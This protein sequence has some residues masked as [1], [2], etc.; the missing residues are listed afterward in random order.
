MTPVRVLSERLRSCNP[1][2][3]IIGTEA[4]NYGYLAELRPEQGLSAM[5]SGQPFGLDP[6][7]GCGP[8]ANWPRRCGARSRRQTSAV[9]DRQHRHLGLR[10]RRS[11]GPGKSRLQRHAMPLL[12]ST[13]A[14]W[15]Q[16]SS[17]R[18]RRP[19]PARGMPAAPD[20]GAFAGSVQPML[21]SRKKSKSRILSALKPPHH[22]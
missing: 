22:A 3:C 15:R 14:P 11:S 6:G 19:Q 9:T 13:K 12:R 8:E 18:S 16:R 2:V 1:T 21:R 17:R 4:R 10:G 20:A 7:T 5:S